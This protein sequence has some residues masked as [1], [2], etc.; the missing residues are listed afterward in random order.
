M[1]PLKPQTFNDGVVNI[2]SVGNTAPPGDMPKEGLTLKV[3]PLR[4]KERTVGMNRFWTAMQN[5][6]RVDLLLRV[7]QIREVSTH[8]VAIPSDGQQYKI[9]QIQYPEEIK[10]PVMDLSLERIDKAYD[11]A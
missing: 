10:P 3:G 9:M 11:L 4:Y 6:S 5:Q 2:Y 1:K 8:D 7:P